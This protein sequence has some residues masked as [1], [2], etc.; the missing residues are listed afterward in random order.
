MASK[1][2]AGVL[3]VSVDGEGRFRTRPP[4]LRELFDLML[5][6]VE[7]TSTEAGES[8]QNGLAKVKSVDWW[9]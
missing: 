1:G 9:R 5:N 6:L 3:G 2:E 8:T 4:P 7:T